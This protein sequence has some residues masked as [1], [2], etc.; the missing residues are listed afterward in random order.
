MKTSVIFKC[1]HVAY[2]QFH[3]KLK[4]DLDLKGYPAASLKATL[5]FVI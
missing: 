4:T 3:Y 1:D 5:L 2:E